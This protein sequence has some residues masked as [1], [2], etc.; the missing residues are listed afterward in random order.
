M[1]AYDIIKKKRDGE[2]LSTRE[3]DFFIEAYTRG[4]IPDYQASAFL[5]ALFFRGMNESETADLTLAM[6]N[7]GERADL[8]QINGIKVDKHSTGGVGDK[9]SLIITPIVAACGVKVAKMS[10]RGLG[11]T[12]G[13]V[14]KLEAIPGFRTDIPKAEFIDIVN[15][16]GLSLIGQSGNFAPAD[17]KLYALRD[18]TATVESIPL[19]ASSIMSKKIASGCDRILLDVKTGSGSFM[20]S[21]EQAQALAQAMV[22]I[23]KN[24][25][26][27]TLALIT[28]MDIPLGYSIGNTLEVVESINTLKGSGPQ[29]LTDLCISL[30]A[31]MLLLADKGSYSDCQEM[32]K[33][34]LYSGKALEKLAQMVEAQGGDREYIEDSSKFTPA[35]YYRTINAYS[36]GYITK[37]NS[38]SCGLA[39][40]ILGAGRARKED[41]IDH[42]AGIVLESKYGD[43][44]EE[45]SPIATLYSEKEELFDEAQRILLNAIEIGFNAPKELDIVLGQVK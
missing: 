18:V 25:G 23:G 28:N 26:R 30:S 27:Q 29:D 3:I 7:S 11:H 6:V 36:T 15:K 8:S 17:K 20:K 39:A 5:M 38:E 43:L 35:K 21:F 13:T 41:K 40:V 9:T 42:A 4:E 10:G 45:G 31:N 44:V 14:D 16:Y 1:R 2:I 22:D 19:I 37:I 24:V 34:A 33:D 12:G 32:A